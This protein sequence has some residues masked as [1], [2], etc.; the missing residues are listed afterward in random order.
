M[1]RNSP[2]SQAL[3][4]WRQM[5]INE[6]PTVDRAIQGRRSLEHTVTNTMVG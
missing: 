4:S 5:S 1:S 2:T 6:F 3:D